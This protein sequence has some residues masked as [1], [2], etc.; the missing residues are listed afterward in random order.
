MVT[1]RSIYNEKET[2][3][4]RVLHL[5]AQVYK[6]YT[7]SKQGRGT[8]LPGHKTPAA[9]CR[10]SLVM[11]TTSRRCIARDSPRR[12]RYKLPARDSVR[13]GARL[14]GTSGAARHE[15][16]R[17]YEDASFSGQGQRDRRQ[18][19]SD[20]KGINTTVNLTTTNLTKPVLP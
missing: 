11:V 10:D 14:I 16:P 17:K 2:G 8:R 18:S 19:R 20:N 5:V 4:E 7:S 15:T 3:K 9:Q 1:G 6:I 13:R 12:R